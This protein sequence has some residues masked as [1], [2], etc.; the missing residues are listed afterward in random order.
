MDVQVMLPSA[1]DVPG[2][3]DVLQAA[4][5]ELLH[6][7]SAA[8]SLGVCQAASSEQWQSLDRMS[9]H[10]GELSS[11]LLA[12]SYAVPDIQPDLSA[13]LSAVRVGALAARLSAREAVEDDDPGELEL[14]GA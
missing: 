3:P 9:Q 13:A 11:F 4:A 10:L 1:P 2:L 12:V 5:A 8:D 6:L 14:F 7:A